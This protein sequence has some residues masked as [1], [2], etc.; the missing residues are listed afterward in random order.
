MDAHLPYPETTQTKTA[1]PRTE[2][3][4]P[5]DV[6]PIDKEAQKDLQVLRLQAVTQREVQEA[7][8]DAS[9]GEPFT[10][11]L[12]A[13]IKKCQEEDPYCK[14]VARQN[15]HH[16]SQLLDT[17]ANGTTIVPEV[18]RS[19]IGKEVPLLCLAGRVVVPEQTA[20]RHELLRLF[21]DC[22]SSGH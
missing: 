10:D 20:L 6:S 16:R 5:L 18:T 13:L 21:H 12:I 4:P 14:W 8:S 15:L 7:L 11:D 22:P 1:K 19:T 17:S 3:V 9:Q 2:L